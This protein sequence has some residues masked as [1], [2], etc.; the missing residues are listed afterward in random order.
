MV[1]CLTGAVL[2]G[3]YEIGE[4]VGRGKFGV[5]YRAHHNVLD[6]P[7]AVKVLHQEVKPTDTAYLR[8]K[9]E[10]ETASALLHPNIV[11]IYDF[12]CSEN[13]FPF[14]VMDFIDGQLLSAAIKEAKHLPVERAVPIFIQIC[15]GMSEAHEKGIIHRDLRPDNVFLVEKAGQKDFVQIVD[16]GIAKKLKDEYSRKLT[17]EGEVLGTPAFMSPEQI[18]GKDLDARSDIYSLGCLM[19]NA[20]TG[21]LPCIGKNTAE[22]MA[23]HVQSEPFKFEDVAPNVHFPIELKFI[24]NKA[25]KKNPHDRHESMAEVRQLLEACL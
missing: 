10:A 15:A 11:K 5:V 8:F 19:F 16:F 1:E 4:E 2:E 23:F 20:L 17:A 18:M 13:G 22:T 9:R 25:L 12:G 21:G 6:R 24:V 14:V 7:V 3:R